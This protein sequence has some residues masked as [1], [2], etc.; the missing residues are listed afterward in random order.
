M[1]ESFSKNKKFGL[2]CTRVDP[3]VTR[4]YASQNIERCPVELYKCYI[5]HRP[6]QTLSE[7]TAFYLTPIGN[8]KSH[9]WYKT[10]PLGIHTIQSATKDVT[11]SI[12]IEGFVSNSSLRR[13]VQNRLIEGGVNND[14]IQKKTGRISSVADSSYISSK[15]YEKQMSSIIHGEHKDECSS[16]KTVKYSCKVLNS[17]E[18]N[19]SLNTKDQKEAAEDKILIVIENKD[20]K[21]TIT[22]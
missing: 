13:T 14:I 15:N 9:I 17:V 22:L 11:K 8:P 18:N 19:L 12:E 21:V 7:T 6:L 16:S 10:T 20:K 2:K 4:L 5:S 1:I 3:K